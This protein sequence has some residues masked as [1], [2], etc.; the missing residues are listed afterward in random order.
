VATLDGSAAFRALHAQPR[1]LILPNVWDAASAALFRAA[2]AHAI[3][4][5]SA[6][7]AWSCGY[8]D[9]DVLPTA[10]L[11]SA[12]DRIR[13]ISIGIPLSVDVEAGYSDDPNEAT[14]LVERLIDAGVAGI[15]LED[16]GGDPSALAAKIEGIARLRQDG[17]D[18]FVNARADVYLRELAHGDEA[19]RETIARGLTYASA[20]ADGLFVP[21]LSEPEAIAAIAGSCPI[22]LSV[23][24]VPSLPDANELFRL[25]VRRL[26]AG[27]SLAALAYGSAREAAV[28]F[29]RNGSSKAVLSTHNVDYDQTNALFQRASA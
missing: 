20:G 5:T 11:L 12:V 6:G 21:G 22:P 17:K 4:T 9:G 8:P 27:E 29:L 28:A 16:E 18:I 2:G 13:R 25:G 10:V 7:L 1:I 24:A 19:V 15:N 3:A 23:F 26:S 14:Q